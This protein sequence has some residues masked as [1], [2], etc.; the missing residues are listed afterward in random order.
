MLLGPDCC[1]KSRRGNRNQTVTGKILVRGQGAGVKCQGTIR[2]AVHHVIYLGA[3]P[4][5]PL[6]FRDVRPCQITLSIECWCIMLSIWLSST[7][8]SRYIHVSSPSAICSENEELV[9]RKYD[10]LQL[11]GHV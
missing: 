5:L 8:F 3:A 2:E 9:F 7:I 4:L 6:G 10:P 1:R 11:V